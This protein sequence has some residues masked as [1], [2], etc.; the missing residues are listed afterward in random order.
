MNPIP[1]I[2]LLSPT[3]VD[4]NSAGF[5]LTITGSDFISTSVIYLDSVALI[6]T[7]VSDTQLTAAVATSNIAIQDNYVSVTVVNPPSTDGGTDGGT[8]NVLIFVVNMSLADSQA[9]MCDL[10]DSLRISYCNG[11]FSWNGN[12]WNCDPTS[13]NNI[14]GAN[15]LALANGGNLPAGFQWRTFTNIMVTVTGADMVQMGAT[16]F[17]FLSNCYTATWEHKANINALTTTSA[18]LAYDYVDTL[19]PAP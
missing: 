9:Y 8:S 18:V 17:T 16:M 3:N 10:V 1:V 4:T 11:Y 2:D 6:T 15:V 13:Q 7:Y 5:T 12:T 19:W 14:I